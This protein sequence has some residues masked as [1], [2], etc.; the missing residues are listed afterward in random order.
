[1][2]SCAICNKRKIIAPKSALGSLMG[3]SPSCNA[4]LVNEV[5]NQLA[6]WDIYEQEISTCHF[7]LN[8]L[9]ENLGFDTVSQAEFLIWLRE[10]HGHSALAVNSFLGLLHALD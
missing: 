7:K 3:C 8:L 2:Y 5:R 6:I 9:L 1:M 10:K 4:L